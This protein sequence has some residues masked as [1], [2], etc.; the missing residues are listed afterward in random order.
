MRGLTFEVAR[1]TRRKYWSERA[2]IY[3]GEEVPKMTIVSH[4]LHLAP[5]IRTYVVVVATPWALR[6]RDIC[7]R[8]PGAPIR[9]ELRS[10]SQIRTA[11][12]GHASCSCHRHRSDPCEFSHTRY[13]EDSASVAVPQQAFPEHSR[14]SK[15]HEYLGKRVLSPAS[16]TFPC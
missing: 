9:T 7:R 12:A 6:R 16:E 11:M 4:N 8:R 2:L 13:V 10:T 15:R 3:P 14:L 5:E 1:A